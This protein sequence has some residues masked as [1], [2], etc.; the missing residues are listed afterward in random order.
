MTWPRARGPWWR[1]APW[2]RVLSR[3]G[4]SLGLTSP[5]ARAARTRRTLS[6]VFR[7][8]NVPR[9]VLYVGQPGA[10]R[11]IV[12]QDTEGRRYL[13]FG[14]DS[15]YQSVTGQGFPLQLELEYTQGM[16]A[17]VA[18]VAQ[19]R[20]ILMVGVGAGSLP[21]FLRAA[22]P[23]VHIDAV[24]C[25]AEVLDVARRYFGLREDAQLR[26]HLE[27]GRRF[28]ETPGPAYDVILLDAFG[29]RGVPR[30]LATWEF[31]RAVRSRLTPDGAVVS[32]VHRSPN[33]LYPAMLQTW[34]A[35]FEQ[36]H[37]FDARTTANRVFVGL[38]T[39]RKVSRG[40]LKARAGPL[41]R[42][43]RFNLRGLMT[44]RLEDREVRRTAEQGLPWPLTAG[45]LRDSDE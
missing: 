15:A 3:S 37:A 28:I 41:A 27:D 26:L 18:F 24:D 20:R 11:C 14:W 42:A 36:L 39:S 10:Y 40:T 32:N 43:A 19:P 5:G 23:Q 44:R 7:W 45:I 16:V 6:R 38:T 8:L 30:S 29:P 17:G 1:Q 4:A 22:L 33:P 35:S 34:R 9:T 31:L 2:T 12:S 21:M 13:Q 25:D